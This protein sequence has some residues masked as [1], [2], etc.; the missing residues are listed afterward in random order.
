MA[1]EI[2]TTD[3]SKFGH[4]EKRLAATL[5]TAMCEQGLPDD[6]ED[7]GVTVMFNTH[8]GNVFLTNA[9]FQVAMMNGEKLES[10][11]YCPNCGH[12]GFKDDMPHGFD[13]DECQ[14]YV[15]D[16]GALE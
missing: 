10:W 7:D 15:C 12:E 4:R 16:I 11:Y 6:F 8:S 3:L 5:L 9:E 14:R 2:T 13:D 1:H